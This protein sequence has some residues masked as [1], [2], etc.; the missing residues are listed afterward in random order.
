MKIT[1]RQLRRIIRESLNEAKAPPTDATI[2]M[3]M[4]QFKVSD[5]PYEVAVEIGEEYG[6]S[7]KQIEKA[8][9]LIRRK[10]IK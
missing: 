6:W 1:K 9:A 5:D 8:E 4:S 10:Y 3:H 7:Q 2:K